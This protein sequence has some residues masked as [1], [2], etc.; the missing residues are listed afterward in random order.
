MKPRRAGHLYVSGTPACGKIDLMSK[1]SVRDN[2]SFDFDVCLSFAGEDRPYV[3]QVADLLRGRG[4]RVFYDEYEQVDLWGKDLYVHL[5]DVYR[6]AARY[7]ILFASDAYA[8]KL[9]TNHERQSAQARAFEEHAEYLLPARFDDTAVPGLRPTIGYIDL[10]KLPAEEFAEL[11]IK[12]V[13]YWVKKDYFPPVPDRL[14]AALGLRG[15]RQKEKALGDAHRFFSVLRRMSVDERRAITAAFVY[16]C[17]A[18]LPDNIHINIDLL[19]RYTGLA[20]SKLKRLLG[21]LQSL[22]FYCSLRQDDETEGHLGKYEMLVIEWNN[23]SDPNNATTL[24]V[25]M[26]VTATSDYCEDCAAKVI[27]R[28]DFSNLSTATADGHVSSEP[29]AT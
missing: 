19:R 5:D 4:V 29:S 20:P 13:G 27:E 26:L 1:P 11:V 10:R 17:P 15:K 14:Y 23:M 22:G 2:E 8:K 7:C 9:W 16:G 12:K 28:L 3:S 24:A 18:E 6:N 25:E 21:G